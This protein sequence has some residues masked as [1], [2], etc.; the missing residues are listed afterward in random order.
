MNEFSQSGAQRPSPPGGP[1]DCATADLWLAE[2][3]EENLPSEIG[4]QLH[5]HA[6]DCAA[7]REKLDQA[8]RGRD[9]LTILK[10]EPLEPPAD[11]V[12]RILVRTSLADVAAATSAAHHV[13]LPNDWASMFGVAGKSS[14]PDAASAN[15]RAAVHPGPATFARGKYVQVP[16][17][18]GTLPAWQRN[19]L[20]AMRH[21]VLEPRL[22]LVAA[23]AFFS[24]SLTLNLL[25]IHL[26]HFRVADLQPQ[27]LRRTVTRHYADANAHVVRYYENL[28]IVYEV[29]ARVQQLRRAA[30]MAPNPPAASDG[31]KGSSDSSHDPGRGPRSHRNAMADH[32]KQP[33]EKNDIVPEP[34]PVFAGPRI[35]VAFPALRRT[36]GMLRIYIDERR[37]A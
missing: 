32:H 2:A 27:N 12:A 35:D 14:D 17:P 21:K 8:R 28:R 6:A 7:C 13:P 30:E 20:V 24:I 26:T 34:V 16:A 9:W 37:L 3:A 1:L 11:L 19:S 33:V 5:G 31:P 10:Q 22:A 15:T 23:M 29:E 36:E 25:G 18:N 4:L